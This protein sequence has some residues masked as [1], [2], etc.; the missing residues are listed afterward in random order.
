M[1][2]AFYQKACCGDSLICCNENCN[3]QIRYGK[4]NLLQFNKSKNT[5]SVCRNLVD[6]IPDLAVNIWKF[7][8]SA[9]EMTVMMERQGGEARKRDKEAIC[10]Y[11]RSKQKTNC[12]WHCNKINKGCNN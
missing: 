8:N 9:R 11:R 7:D 1:C 10:T 6:F 2:L 12:R 5:C 4:E 3:F